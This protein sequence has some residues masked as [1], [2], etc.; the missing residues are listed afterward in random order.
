MP[1]LFRDFETR[2]TLHLPD[3]GAWKYAGDASTDVWC[4][5]YAV[6]DGPAQTWLPGQPVPEAF[7]IAATDPTWI[8][9]AHND[10]FESAI[11]ERLLGPRY[12][13]PIVPIERHRCTQA[14]ALAAALPAKLET[15]AAALQLPIGKDT[16]GARLMREMARPRKPRAGEDP[17]GVYWVDDLD[18]L[19]RLIAYNIRDV[20]IEREL[21]PRLP[22]LSD[23]EQILWQLDAAVNRR[24]F[25]VDVPL[26]EAAD[27]IVRER[28]SVINRELTELTGGRITSIAQVNRLA[29]YLKERGHK[30]AGVGKRSVAAVLANNPAAD[31]ER[32]LRQRQEGGRSSA[33]KID[34]LLAM[35]ND[36][37]IHGALKFHGA[38]TGRWSGH[39]F[40]PHNL[41]RAQPTDAVA[42]IAAV[43]SG[44]LARVAAIGPPLE[45][46]GSLS[47]ALI[48]AAP[49]KM[50]ISADYSAVES[51][52]L[53]RLAGENWKLEA[54]QKFDAT[55]DPALEPYC[56]TATRI[57][58]RSV[59]P[60]DEDGRQVGKLCDLAFGFG[61]GGGAFNRIAPDAGFTDA[62]VET[63]KRQWRAAHPKIVKFWGDLHRTLLRAVRTGKP[64]ELRNLRAEMRAGTLYLRLPSGR[65][66]AYP[67]ARIKAGQCDDQ[68]VFKDSAI[69]KWR[70]VRGWHG[71]FTENV[72][73]A[74]SRDLLA[75]A[76]QRLEAAGY[77]IVLHVHDEVVA[78][79]AED[80]GTPEEF[81]RIM[82]ELPMWAT[83][84]PLVAKSSRRKRYARETNR[85]ANDDPD[86]ENEAT[87]VTQADLDAINAGLKREGIEP[88]DSDAA[89][90]H[91]N[92]PAP[93]DHQE[94]QSAQTARDDPFV[95][96]AGG[97]ERTG[98][99]RVRYVYTDEQGA[100]HHRKIRTD[101]KKFW[102]EKREC[103]RWVKGAPQ[104]KYLYNIGQL[105]AAPLGTTIWITEGEKDAESLNALG[106]LAVTNPGGAGKWHSDFTDEQTERWF[107]R[108]QTVY[109]TED[110]DAPGRRHVEIIARALQRLVG[111]IRI[112]TFRDLP[113]KGDVTD[114]LELRHSK[115]ELLARAEAAPRYE[116]DA[117]E[118]ITADELQNMVF[119]PINFVVPGFIAEGLTLFA[120]KPK[121]GKSWLLMHAARAVASGGATLGGIKVEAGDVFY[122]ALE[123]N[124]RR[125]SRRMTRLFGQEQWPPRLHFTCKMS[126]LAEGGL[127]EIKAWIKKARCPRLII[128][129]TLKMVRTPARKD[130]NYYEADYESVRELRD[131]AAEHAIAIV[132]VHHLRK[133]EADDPFDTVSGTLGLTGAVDTVMLLWRQGNG[134]VLAAK[135]R[136]VEETTKAVVFNRD[137]CTWTIIGDADEVKRS[138]ERENI[139]K[140]FAEAGAEPLSPNQIAAATGMKPTNVRKL[141]QRMK[142]DGLIK[143]AKYGKY[144]LNID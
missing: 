34:S 119:A 132:V 46:V 126:K 111:E 89:Q 43:M 117:I 73:Q 95:H 68:I 47:R 61:G 21:Y 124:Q 91:V 51:R 106:L 70:E 115:A 15:I 49:G 127:A 55:G 85:N 12:G 62:Q 67:E 36:D 7:Q 44:D 110:N 137:T 14:M 13:W 129:D 88:I 31:V 136:D 76:M 1:V 20:E 50:L 28:R 83:G 112:V 5:G 82:V 92:G 101:T 104:I 109:L 84:L 19:R 4:V 94:R 10:A 8:V 57:L 32:L 11:E 25:H 142:V 64:Q 52:V 75:A 80:F 29:E 58:G 71:T 39:G 45:V 69:G 102:Q 78:E 108:P 122:A 9:V 54:Y 130:Q 144:V 133:A 123:D 96:Y 125:L 87:P 114:W 33:G 23:A 60:D 41:S 138:N 63:F 16:E 6:D 141:M 65:E 128:I 18:K 26:A 42:A 97:E 118:I 98:H 74:V 100:P 135:G 121:I 59:T 143:A 105:L 17:H 2:S 139:L 48:C 3:V 53:S 81:A 37:R 131:L 56:V 90:P 77:T 93:V 140:A 99:P 116:P 79:V 72:V 107:K 30:V 40:Q 24:G 38:S 120:G 134:V 103:N 35:A 22:P 27:K 86:D 66:I 113:E